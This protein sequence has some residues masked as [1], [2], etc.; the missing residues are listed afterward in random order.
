MPRNY[1]LLLHDA[2]R[3]HMVSLDARGRERLREKLEFLQAGLWDTGVRV[4]KLKGSGRAVFEARLSRGDRIL[5]TLGEPPKGEPPAGA[6]NGG[7]VTRIYVWAVVQH[8]DVTAAAERRIVPANA[9]FLDF[10]PALVEELPEFVADDLGGDYF[11]PAL[12]QPVAVPGAAGAAGGAVDV[13]DAAVDAGPQRWLVVDDQEWRRLLAAHDGDHLELYLFLTREQARLLHSEP[14]L[15]LSG[16]AGSG[17]TTIAVYFLLRHRVRR[18][19]PAPDAATAPADPGTRAVSADPG[20]RGNA[21]ERSGTL[22]RTLRRTA[23]PGLQRR[24]ARTRRQQF[25]AQAPGVQLPGGRPP[26]VQAPKD[27]PLGRRPRAGPPARSPA[28]WAPPT[29]VSD[30]RVPSGRCFLPA[31][32]T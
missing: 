1:A 29:R 24:V 18:L 10:E 32:L 16:T 20:A 9:P 22:R 31:A 21:G 6:A 28:G 17:K 11:S 30:R 8:D 27:R 7:G 3:D 15:L 5:F 23:R 13:G 25:R 14:P 12:D 19:T 2:V 26:G 4:K